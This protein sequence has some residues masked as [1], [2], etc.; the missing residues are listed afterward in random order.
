M[1]LAAY[2]ATS[3]SVTGIA[4]QMAPGPAH[5][6][7]SRIS[8]PLTAHPLSTDTANAAPGRSSAWK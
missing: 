7:S 5:R 2:T 4:S 6:G 8:A 1:A 3:S